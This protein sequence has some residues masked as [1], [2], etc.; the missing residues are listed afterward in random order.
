MGEGTDQA[1]VSRHTGWSLYFPVHMPGLEIS[2]SIEGGDDIDI[3]ADMIDLAEH[4]NSF[5][6]EA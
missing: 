2:Q 1:D 4:A 6:A 5:F 3:E